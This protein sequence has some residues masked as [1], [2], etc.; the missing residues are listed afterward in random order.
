MSGQPCQL[1]PSHPA[2]GPAGRQGLVPLDSH[3][4]GMEWGDELAGKGPRGGHGGGVVRARGALTGGWPHPGSAAH[5]DGPV[6][7]LHWPDAGLQPGGPCS[8]VP[9]L[10][11]CGRWPTAPTEW[12]LA[13]RGLRWAPRGHVEALDPRTAGR[14]PLKMDQGTMASSAGALPEGDTGQGVQ[15][16]GCED[17]GGGG[18]CKERPGAAGPAWACTL[19]L[20]KVVASGGWADPHTLVLS[21]KDKG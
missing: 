21:P 3:V 20:S 18:G 7:Q 5:S 13:P 12:P 19:G 2:Q 11:C 16:A 9:W 1:G 4:G 8:A 15:K 6:A 17:S 10:L 14:G